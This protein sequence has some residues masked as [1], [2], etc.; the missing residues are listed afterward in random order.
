MTVLMDLVPVRTLTDY[1]KY[2]G[3]LF[4]KRAIDKYTL[5]KELST[6]PIQF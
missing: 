4:E 2:S 5:D 1:E 6:K 3:I